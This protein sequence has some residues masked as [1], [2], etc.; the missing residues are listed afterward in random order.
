MTQRELILHNLLTV[1]YA[2]INNLYSPT[3]KTANNST[4]KGLAILDAIPN[5][6]DKKE[7]N[8][9]KIKKALKS[10]SKEAFKTAIQEVI[11]FSVFS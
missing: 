11:K 8:L 7:T 4:L 6:I 9:D 3:A 5:A 2:T 10:G 1:K